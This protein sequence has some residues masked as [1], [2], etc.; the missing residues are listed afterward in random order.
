MQKP[1]LPLQG[2]WL[3]MIFML[4]QGL[5]LL[6]IIWKEINSNIFYIFLNETKFFEHL[7]L[8]LIMNITYDC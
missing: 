8:L 4:R 5:C 7:L 3:R 1:L 2:L 6:L